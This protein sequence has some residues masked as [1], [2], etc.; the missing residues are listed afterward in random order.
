[1]RLAILLLSFPLV[2]SAQSGPSAGTV[3]GGVD[4]ASQAF[5]VDHS[6]I[7]VKDFGAVGDSVT[8]N[9]AAFNSAI[10]YSKAHGSVPLYVP[11]GN[12]FFADSVDLQDVSITGAPILGGGG[13][14]G[15]SLIGAPCHDIFASKDFADSGIKTLWGDYFKISNLTMLVDVS[16]DA[17]DQFN[18]VVNTSGTTVTWVSGSKF[19]CLINGPGTPSVRINGTTYNVSSATDTT[20][21]L[22]SDAGTQ[23]GATLWSAGTWVNRKR[24]A[25][26]RSAFSNNPASWAGQTLGA[27]KAIGA[28]T[29]TLGTAPILNQSWGV[30]AKGAIQIVANVCNYYGIVGAVLQNVTCG[31]QGTADISGAIGAP[32]AAVNP[33]DYKNTAD[34][35]PGEEVGNAAIAFPWRDAMQ[36]N[37][38]VTGASL[39][40]IR[41]LTHHQPAGN[42]NNGQHTAGFYFQIP[43][44]SVHFSNLSARFTTFGYTEAQAAMHIAFEIQGQAS[45]DASIFENFEIHAPVP[46]VA[47]AGN[48]VHVKN[49]QLYS[50]TQA[51]PIKQQSRGL[52]LLDPTVSQ[53]ECDAI[54]GCMFRSMPMGDW[55]IDNMYNEP[56]FYG[57]PFYGPYAQIQGGS[58]HFTVG[59]MGSQPGPVIWDASASSTEAVA[60][61]AYLAPALIINGFGNKF[62]NAGGIPI[63]G[64]IQDNSQGGTEYDGIGIYGIKESLQIPAR[65]GPAGRIDGDFLR[66]GNDTYRSGDGLFLSPENILSWQ[67]SGTQHV[68]HD[69]SAPITGQYLVLSAH[70]G[71]DLLGRINGSDAWRV[72]QSFPIGTGKII[73]KARA[74]ANTS[75][76]IQVTSNGA[77]I[78]S[79]VC[80]WT[81]G[82]WTKCVL[83]FNTTGRAGEQIKVIGQW[84]G[85]DNTLNPPTEL[86]VAYVGAV[87]DVIPW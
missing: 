5:V 9:R 17:T 44:Y 23:A 28:T 39:D 76:T 43:P 19:A 86:D 22:A 59:L 73:V 2:C 12:Y 66:T 50:G 33:W 26:Q 68:V 57:A 60:L 30:A 63:P 84:N 49:F 47:V 1:M 34:D 55:Q 11:P 77:Q 69:A 25:L 51:D 14:L 71:V 64:A 46:F 38:S 24:W 79:A 67:A 6:S 10:I 3:A 13:P 74:V 35:F 65:F 82:V 85:V 48:Y 61:M 80:T 31:M 20:I 45:A 29:I 42:N 53:S 41:V 83:P 4:M 72:G 87:P 27:T 62:H 21:T 56:G 32:V 15:T 8:D 70:P 18:S 40:R 7:S 58:H 16:R 75:G 54:G 36:G 78:G 52:I 81:A 37:N